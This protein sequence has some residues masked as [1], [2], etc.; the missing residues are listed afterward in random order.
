M[1]PTGEA[2]S[3]ANACPERDLTGEG[4]VCA[5]T[6]NAS[7]SRERKGV[8]DR[9]PEGKGPSMGRDRQPPPLPSLLLHISSTET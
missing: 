5:G 7:T 3:L 1:I 8:Q 4:W 2:M 9:L 6:S